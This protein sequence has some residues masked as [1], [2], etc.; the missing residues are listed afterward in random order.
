MSVCLCVCACVYAC[1]CVCVR[2][3][4]CMC[5]CVR[6]YMEGEREVIGKYLEFDMYCVHF[7]QDYTNYCRSLYRSTNPCRVYRECSFPFCIQ[8]PGVQVISIA[9]AKKQAHP[10]DEMRLWKFIN[11]VFSQLKHDCPIFGILVIGET[12][13]GKSTLINNLLGKEVAKVG[14]TMYSQ[15]LFVTPHELSVEGV[16]VVVYDTPGLE[17][18]GADEDEKKHLEIMES[19]LA[20]GKIHLVIYCL[21]MTET[22]MRKGLIRTFE[23]YHKIGVP[24][25]RTVITLTFADRVEDTTSG[26]LFEMRQ[27]VKATLTERVGVRSSTSERVKICPTAKDPSIA[28]PTGRPWYVPFWLDVVE[29]LV[30]A[31]LVQFLRI[32]NDSIHMES[33]PASSHSKPVRVTL[34]GEDKERFQREVIRLSGVCVCGVCV[35]MML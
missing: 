18:T 31:A 20:R 4:V 33:M 7:N 28:L 9:K 16:P 15:T 22:R 35:S 29:V 8:Q 11:G 1:M 6:V 12:G 3:C 32:H 14:H 19:L 34:V 30:P 5:V 17:D 23:E 21:K 24:W 25:E 26:K 27:Q 10:E 2:V 13:T